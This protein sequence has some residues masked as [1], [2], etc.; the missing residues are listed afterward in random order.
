MRLF[1]NATSTSVN[2]ESL[3]FEMTVMSVRM[4]KKINVD[5]DYDEEYRND[6]DDDYG[7]DCYHLD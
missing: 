4:I 6:L 1:I 7:D 2:F 5:N 3:D